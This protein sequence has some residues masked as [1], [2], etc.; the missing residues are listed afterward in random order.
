MEGV[1]SNDRI[2]SIGDY[3]KYLN[4]AGYLQ[5]YGSLD[6]LNHIRMPVLLESCG[7]AKAKLLIIADHLNYEKSLINKFIPLSNDISMNS[8]DD[9]MK[10]LKAVASLL[11]VNLIKNLWGMNKE[12]NGRIMTNLYKNLGAGH[13]LGACLNSR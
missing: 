4:D 5:I 13:Y 6:F 9:E 2:P 1:S 11:D 7:V 10:L 8:I 12:R 3:K